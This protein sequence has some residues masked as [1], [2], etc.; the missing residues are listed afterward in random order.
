MAR[1]LPPGGTFVDDDGNLQ[2]GNI[3]AIAALGI[4]RGRNPPENDH[5]VLH[6][7]HTVPGSAFEA[8]SVESLIIDPDSGAALP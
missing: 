1:A 8:V 2:E 4:T 5:S 6:G 3:E 7:L